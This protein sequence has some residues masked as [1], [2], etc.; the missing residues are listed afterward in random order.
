M[1]EK[2]ELLLKVYRKKLEEINIPPI[3]YMEGIR[4][5]AII[6]ILEHLYVYALQEEGK[7]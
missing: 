6:G 2:I 7:K 4:V 1:K 5:N 3:D